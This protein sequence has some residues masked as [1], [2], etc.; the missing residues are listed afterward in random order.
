VRRETEETAPRADVEK[1]QPGEG[2]A[3]EHPAQRHDGPLDVLLRDAL[4]KLPPV[5]AELEAFASRDFRGVGI[6][7]VAGKRVG[8]HGC[9]H[10]GEILVERSHCM[11]MSSGQS[12]SA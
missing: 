8:Q 3:A 11:A 10:E 1:A 5:L 12:R 6:G 7:G 2:L 9:G 4:E